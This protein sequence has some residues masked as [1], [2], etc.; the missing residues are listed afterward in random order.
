[1]S[2]HHHLFGYESLSEEFQQVALF[3]DAALWCWSDHGVSSGYRHTA[4]QAEAQSIEAWREN[5]ADWY[6]TMAGA[7]SFERHDAEEKGGKTRLHEH[8]SS[9]FDCHFAPWISQ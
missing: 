1:M 2:R 4:L 8:L 3:R 9:A 5:W 7:E 6:A